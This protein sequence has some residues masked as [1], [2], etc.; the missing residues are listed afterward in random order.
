VKCPATGDLV[1]KEKHLAMVIQKPYD[2]QQIA[3]AA[4]AL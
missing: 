2:L 4:W 1:I 3:K